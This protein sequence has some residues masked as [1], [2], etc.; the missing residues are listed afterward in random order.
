MIPD[1]A[2]SRSLKASILVV[3]YG[4]V[5]AATACLLGRLGVHTIVID[6]SN[7]VFAQPR[8]IALDNEALR[9]LQMAGLADDAFARIAIPYVKL[10]SP[11]FGQFGQVNTAGSLDGHPKLVTFA[12]PELEAALRRQVATLPSVE[13]ALGLQVVRIEESADEVITTVRDPEGRERRIHS[14]YVVGADGASSFVRGAIGQEFRGRS[15]AEDWLIIDA[16]DVPHP[17]D[18]IEFIC[19]PRRPTPHMPSPGGR[20]RWEFMLAPG[21]AREEM[22]SDVRIA[23]LLRPWL[24]PGQLRVERRAVYRFHARCCEAFGK[25]RVALAG[26]AAHITPPFVGQ[27]LV[28]GLRDAANLAWKLAAIVQG[29]AAPGILASYDT[30]RRPHAKAM[31][32]LARLMGS[33]VMPRSATRA[34]LLHGM[35]RLA[36]SIPVL[37][38][39]FDGLGLK[40]RNRFREGLFLRGRSDARLVR[41]API[42]QGLVRGADGTILRSD[43]ALGQGFTLVGFGVD[44]SRHLSEEVRDTWVARGGGIVQ[45]CHAAQTLHRG[46]RA[47]EDLQGVLVPD[48]APVGWAAVVRPDRVVVTDGPAVDAHKLLAQTTALLAA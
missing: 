16:L 20:E 41:G 39:L 28:A 29:R 47:F 9:I 4:P 44:P 24:E 37:R 43:D 33:L 5:G 34:V 23:E 32:D 48:A 38:R 8:A 46:E 6:K 27:G 22:E 12:Q 10:H 15:Y 1:E 17:I 36:R 45:F 31:I 2:S 26:D 35:M 19:D 11:F 7:T 30:E 18:H 3:G 21:E 42:P 25:G 14:A 40:P 13:V